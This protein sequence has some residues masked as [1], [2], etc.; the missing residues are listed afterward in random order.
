MVSPDQEAEHGNGN[1]R[2]RDEAVA[3]DA[4]SRET[5]DDFRHDAHR[6]QNHDVDR[7]MGIEP[8]KVLE[9]DRIASEFGIEDAKVQSAFGRDHHE[10]NGEDRRA[11]K[12]ND[13]GSVVRPDEQWKAR[14]HEAG[15]A[16]AMDSDDEVQAG[17]DGGESRDEDGESRFNNLAVGVIG[18][19]GSVERPPGIDAAGQHAVQHHHAADDVEIPTEQVDAGESEVLGPDHQGHEKISEYSGDGRNEEEKNHDHAMHGEELVVGIG[20][21]QVAR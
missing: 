8:E 10:G 5:G 20:L 18:A 4:F 3:E 13:A 14:P 16:H 7:G 19:E 2:E 12:L 1:R 9:E 6:G 17:E 11:K 15:R 21:N